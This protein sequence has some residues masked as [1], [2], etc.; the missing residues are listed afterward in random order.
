M[1]IQAFRA[2]GQGVG[3]V[4]VMA[5][6]QHLDAPMRARDHFLNSIHPDSVIDHHPNLTFYISEDLWASISFSLP[7]VLAFFFFVVGLIV[8]RLVRGSA[9][10]RFM[11][12]DEAEIGI[13]DQKIRLKP[14]EV[15]RQIAY[16]VWVELSTRKIGLEIDP[17]H[18]VIS[19]IYDSWYSFFS[20]TREL[21][22]DVPAT[23]IS[24]KDTEQIIRLSIEV[25]NNGI[26]PHLTQWQ[27]RFRRWYE[28]Q[29]TLGEN[30]ATHPQD[31]QKNFPGYPELIEDMLLVNQ[32]LIHY[33]NH[34]YRLVTGRRSD[35]LRPARNKTDPPL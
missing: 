11:E 29:L 32:S 5:L 21:I 15:D 7:L 26:R 14:N 27:A 35:P 1:R 19:E 28:K 12:I 20:V 24:R 17:D 31:I 4:A 18:D 8:W 16:Q 23:K 2:S 10:T 9:F 30:A 22:K 34:M 13:G 3:L 6:G 25:L 33:R